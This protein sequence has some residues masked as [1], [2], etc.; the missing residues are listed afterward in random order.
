MLDCLCRGHASGE[1]HDG[2]ERD[3]AGPEP[4][5]RARARRPR[6]GEVQGCQL[7]LQ[8]AGMR[9]VLR[10]PTLFN[11]CGERLRRKGGNRV[12]VRLDG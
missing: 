1:Q 6:P 4:T 3:E 7:S 5:R 8:H 12:D 9:M 11:P 2:G 10:R